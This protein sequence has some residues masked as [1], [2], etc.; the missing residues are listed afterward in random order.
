MNADIATSYVSRVCD[1]PTLVAHAG[2]AEFVRRNPAIV[3]SGWSLRFTG[4]ED[5]S[6]SAVLSAGWAQR[7]A[8]DIE[9]ER[10][11]RDRVLVGMRHRTRQVPWWSTSYFGAA[12]DAVGV[13]IDALE[14][15]ADE[16]LRAVLAQDV[17]LARR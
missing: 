15:W 1:V 10:W 17:G 16:P 9:I 3:T 13:I 7:V 14:E 2:L 8:V 5:A 4:T 11:S 6:V 12:H